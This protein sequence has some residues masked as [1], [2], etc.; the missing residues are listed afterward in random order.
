MNLPI[1]HRKFVSSETCLSKPKLPALALVA[2]T[3]ALSL[4][5]CETLGQWAS[6]G[7]PGP[8]GPHY[9]E[10]DE[11]QQ[12]HASSSSRSNSRPHRSSPWAGSRDDD[13]DD[14]PEDFSPP[15]GNVTESP[16]GNR[17]YRSRQTGA[18]TGSEWTSPAGTTTY[19]DSSGQMTGYSSES[20][21]GT[22]TYRD[23]SGSI[24]MQSSTT[25]G[26]GGDNTTTYRR[27]GT[28]VGTKYVSPAG[29][30]TWRDGSGAIIDGPGQMKP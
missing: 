3:A 26:T 13:D 15:D 6:T 29:N 27:N 16:S 28:I 18:I 11:V 22:R 8:G 17:T 30:V 21:S 4:S 20:P 10:G 12:T 25:E 23:S 19:R 14:G 7:I 9:E 5:G 1:F 24:A 2:L